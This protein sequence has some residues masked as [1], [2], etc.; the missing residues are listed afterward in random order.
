MLTH[1]HPDLPLHVA[2][3]ASPYGL[4]SVLSHPMRD[5]TERPIVFASRTLNSA[6]QNYCQIDKEN[7][8]IVWSLNKFHTYLY[9]RRFTLITDHQPL[10]ANFS[11]VTNLPSMT[12]AC[13]QR[14]A[15]LLTRYQFDIV[16]WKTSDHGNADGLS[17]LPINSRPTETDADGDA[18]HSFHVSIHCL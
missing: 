15:L 17:C 7:L 18:V 6:E 4:G 16:Y 14:H 2:S 8:G 11:P 10:T 1:F 12:A 3:D 9:G 13:L 5:G